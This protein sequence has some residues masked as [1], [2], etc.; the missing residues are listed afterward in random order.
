MSGRIIALCLLAAQT[1]AC[2][3]I[4][5]EPPPSDLVE[6]IDTL[7]DELATEIIFRELFDDND[8]GSRD[9]YDGSSAT[10]ST[11]EHVVGS[12]S[13]LECVFKDGLCKGGS[14]ERR[15][16][17]PP[18]ESLYAS[19]WVKYSSDFTGAS[20]L[21]FASS[22]DDKWVGFADTHL[23]LTFGQDEGY[24]SL[25]TTDN[26]NVD[27]SC[28]KLRSGEL[29]GCGGVAFEDYTFTEARSVSACNGTV[30]DPGIEH[31]CSSSGGGEF[32]S[33]RQFVSSERAFTES[34]GPGL[35]TDWHL[36]EVYVELNSRVNG[37]GVADG[38]LKLWRDG[39][40][41]LDYEQVVWRTGEHLDLAINQVYLHQSAGT[42]TMWM[43]DF[44]LARG[45]K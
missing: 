28:V 24:S 8:F 41:M 16:F 18:V 9:W 33:S 35:K 1:T 36:I 6:D 15:L 17:D 5:Y 11:T 2:G 31:D 34:A 32:W 21:W 29:L 4:G 45:L 14:P 44:S 20:E 13:S 10:I 40:P 26:E 30:G 42:G 37:V 12:K 39:D 7:E 27:G 38:V 19:Y 25:Q 23:T 22:L 3:R 43:D